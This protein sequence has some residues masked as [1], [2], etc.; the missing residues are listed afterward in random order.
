MSDADD[1]RFMH[2]ALLEAAKAEARVD[3]PFGA[4]VVFEGKIV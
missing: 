3:V 1:E 4:F 2:E